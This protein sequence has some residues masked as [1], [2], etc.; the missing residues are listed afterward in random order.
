MVRLDSIEQG[1]VVVVFFDNESPINTREIERGGKVVEVLSVSTGRRGQTHVLAR[2]N[3][4]YLVLGGG[5]AVR[6]DSSFVTRR[7][8]RGSKFDDEY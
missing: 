4:D 6:L 3:M 7:E 5:T 8:L 2:Y 1:R